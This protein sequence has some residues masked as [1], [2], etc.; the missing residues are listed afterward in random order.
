M[1]WRRRERER[2]TGRGFSVYL[3]IVSLKRNREIR[4]KESFRTG[5]GR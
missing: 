3:E 1:Y 5:Q 2:E 4:R